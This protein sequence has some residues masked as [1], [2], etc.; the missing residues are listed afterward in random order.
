MLFDILLGSVT[1]IQPTPVDKSNL[2]S[3]LLQLQR[4]GETMQLTND[5]AEDSQPAWSPD[6]TKLAIFSDQNGNNDIWIVPVSGGPPVVI[7]PPD[8]NDVNPYWSPDGRRIGFTSDRGGRSEIWTMNVD[9]SDARELTDIG[10]LGHTPRWL[11]DGKW[12]LFTSVAKGDRGIWA[13][14]NDGETLRRLTSAPTQDAHGLWSPDG[15]SVVYLSD[16]QKVFAREFD[17]D[18]HRLLFDIDETIDYVHLSAD[19][20]IFVFTRQRV[21]SDVWLIE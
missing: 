11:P 2:L 17:K 10:T 21:E 1:E 9:G 6:D 12:L 8:S 13:V 19:G 7:T 3:L 14:S 20:T 18:K 16:H 4:A 5:T 15:S